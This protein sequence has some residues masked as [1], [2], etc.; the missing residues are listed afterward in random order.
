MAEMKISAIAAWFGGKRTMAPLI[1]QQL[2]IKF[3]QYFEPFC[4]SM[5][6]LF[7]MEQRGFETVN[8][9]H[10][11]LIN[12]AS[13]LQSPLA[14]QLYDRAM[15]T[16]VCEDLLEK[17]E[18]I[19]AEPVDADPYFVPIDRAYWYF[20][21]T[22]M[23]RNGVA[24]TAATDYQMAVR[25]TP[26][27]G[28]PATRFRSCVESIPAWHDRLR[29]VVILRRDAFDIIPKFD[30]AEHTAIYVDPPYPAESRGGGKGVGGHAG[31]YLYEFSH[32]SLY[33]DD[34]ERLAKILREF[35]HARIVVSTYDC[36]RY[37]ELYAGWTFIDCA[38]MKNL[39]QQNGRGQRSKVAPEVL[40]VN[41]PEYLKDHLHMAKQPEPPEAAPRTRLVNR[42]EHLR[43]ASRIVAILEDVDP[44]K[45]AGILKIVQ[46]SLANPEAV[47][48]EVTPQALFAAEA[49]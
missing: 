40:I 39:H 12:L 3:K 6:V 24:G 41:G 22:W 7:A 18:S 32:D 4:G 42:N 14:H 10:G 35:K 27:G 13:I 28:S 49:K 38:R 46:E 31:T 34:H 44:A 5:A 33:G 16:L 23:G 20:V 48:G 15:R 2:G 8:D 19:L 36:P 21:A 43:A 29:N 17:A 26:N 37:R 47:N 30:D 25:W 1:V 45:W 11:D 9:L